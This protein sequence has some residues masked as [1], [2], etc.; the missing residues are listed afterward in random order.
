MNSKGFSIHIVRQHWLGDDP[1]VAKVDLC[2]HG[3][4]RITVGEQVISDGTEDYGVSETA[5]ALLRTLDRDH[6]P[7]SLVAEKLVFHGCGTMLMMGCPIGIDWSVKHLPGDRVRLANIR[8]FDTTNENDAVRFG[9][10]AV[11]IDGSA[12]R[13]EV[14]RFAQGVKRFFDGVAKVPE[15]AYD[16]EQYEHFWQECDTLLARFG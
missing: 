12:Y 4:L 3:G 14:I 10:L 7:A 13:H 11:E 9:D 2:S 1:D 8:R 16:R 15:D 5:L 6:T